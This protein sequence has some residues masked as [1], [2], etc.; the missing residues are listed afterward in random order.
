M[1]LNNFRSPQYG[2]H[3]TTEEIHAKFAPS[4]DTVESVMTWLHENGYNRDDIA[5]STSKGW[6]AFETSA[7]EAEN[8]FS[9]QYYEETN[10][11]GSIGVA[12]D[13]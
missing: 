6:L 11:D 5:S 1:V 3:W 10:A 2:K 8:L 4:E 9:T 7:R 12:C 13:E